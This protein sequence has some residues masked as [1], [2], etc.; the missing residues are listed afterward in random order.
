MEQNISAKIPRIIY[1]DAIGTASEGFL[2]STQAAANLPFPVKRTFW[3]QRVPENYT[4]GHHAHYTTE[5]I[6][7]PLQGSITVTT[8]S[9]AGEQLFTLNR[10]D[11]GLY[12]P[13]KCWVTLSFS[14]EALLLCLASTDYNEADYIRDFDAFRRICLASG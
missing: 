4:R 7:I 3:L 8:Q 2:F 11:A 6:L 9:A 14:A 5:E 13:A 1:F 12:I 10:A